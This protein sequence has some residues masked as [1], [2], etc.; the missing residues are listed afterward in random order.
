MWRH[1]RL[2]AVTTLLTIVGMI[3][4]ACGGGS[5]PAASA[6]AAAAA[7]SS[8]DTVV[9][10]RYA[11]W[12]SAQQ[13]A[14]QACADLFQQEHPNI[15]IKIEQL[16]WD[17]YWNS[18]QTGFVAGTAPD[19]FTNHLAK[20]P[21]FAEKGQIVDIQP[22]VERDKVD[23]SIYIG[24]LADLWAREGKRYGLP[25]DWDTIAVFY[26][27][28]MVADAGIDPKVM[29]EWTWNPQD[30]GTFEEAIARLTIDQ[31]GNN[32]LSPDFD[33]TKVK[34]Y[35]FLPQGSGGGYGQTQWSS[36]A[37]SNGF[38]FQDSVWGS[39]FYYDD[40]RLAETIQWYV[41]LGLKKGYAPAPTD[42]NS[43]GAG[44]LF[45]SGRG[46]MTTDGSWQIK[47]YIENSGFEVGF[48]LLPIG[49]EGRKSMFNGLA[50]SIFVGTKHLE[51]SWEWVKFLAS[52]TCENIVG[53]YA[54]VFPAIQAG[55]EKA[56]EAHKAKGADV[57]AF[58]QEALD[59][60]G[61]FLFPVADHASEVSTIMNQVMDRIY[62]GV[63]TDIAGAL[64]KA[65][66]EVN[67]LFR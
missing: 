57:S 5:A 33:K 32:G 43:M 55:V 2:F 50:D 28:Q 37:A 60:N 42:I 22:L 31:N 17:D 11:L 13:P 14:Y 15:K 65:N 64:Q 25:K 21:E 3:V 19:V 56:L 67:A 46:A 20:Y 35:G 36:F 62:L 51:E 24:A 26:N 40:P 30:G 59:P 45:Q 48:G 18:I 7:A 16:G 9:E 8:A 49:P 63:E 29:E 41:D 27:K 12:D 6:P 61:T 39:K 58:T 23:T 10:I 66:E 34:Q 44:A 4:A 54:V 52:P 47:N 53:E 38:K 1:H